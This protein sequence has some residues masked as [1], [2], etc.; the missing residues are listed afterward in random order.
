MF[1]AQAA[2]EKGAGIHAGRGMALKKDLIPGEI[3]VGRFE[4]VILTHFI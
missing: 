2:F 4:E 3:A 1:G